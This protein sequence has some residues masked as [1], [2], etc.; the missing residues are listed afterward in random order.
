MKAL[1][2]M[3]KSKHSTLLLFTAMETKLL[4]TFSSESVAES[5]SESVGKRSSISVSKRASE[6]VEER[7]SFQMSRSNRI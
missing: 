6:T 1:C 3:S 5:S 4:L 7:I 2:L